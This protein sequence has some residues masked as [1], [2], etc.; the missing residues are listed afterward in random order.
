[1]K[2][3]LQQRLALWGVALGLFGLFVAVVRVNHAE[4]VMANPPTPYILIDAGHG[5]ADG[6][7]VA[8]DGTMEKNINL[9]ISLT[10]ADMLRVFGYRVRTTRDADV[11]IHDAGVEGL[12]HQK[13]S[14]I[15]NRVALA[16]GAA[17]TVSIHQN[18]FPQ[19]QYHGTQVFYSPNHPMSEGVGKAIRGQVI[20]LLQPENTRPLKKGSGDIYLLKHAPTPT[21]LVECGFLSNP[22][23]LEKLKTPDYQRQMAFAITAGVLQHGV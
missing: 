13:V 3:R 23:E 6:G 5:G 10:V 8:T 18:Q 2:K 21:V 4:Q 19:S 15:R 17:L 14:D 20:A 1:M 16:N 7:A 9:P 22:A 12:R 11:S